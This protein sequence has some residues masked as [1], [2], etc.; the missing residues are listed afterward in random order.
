MQFKCDR[1]PWQCL[2][3]RYEKLVLEPKKQIERVLLFL[4][5][6][7]ND[8]VLHHEVEVGSK[9][10]ISKMERSSD[11]IALPINSEALIQ[12]NDFAS[13]F[14]QKAKSLAGTSWV[15]NIPESVKDKVD[16]IAPIMRKLGYDTVNYPPNYG[17]ADALV[18]NN[19]LAIAEDWKKWEERVRHLLSTDSN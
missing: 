12:S 7:W 14:L 3:V 16:E 1:F 8:K 13:G 2:P 18:V 4:G 19:T 11:Q 9:I 15:K 5:L 6:P 10:S 17:K